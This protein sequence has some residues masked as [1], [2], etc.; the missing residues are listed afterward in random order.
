MR[1]P[2]TTITISSGIQL[3]STGVIREFLARIHTRTMDLLFNLVE[4]VVEEISG[5]VVDEVVDERTG[6]ADARQEGGRR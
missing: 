2:P 6:Q 5:E 4:Q 1:S 3:F